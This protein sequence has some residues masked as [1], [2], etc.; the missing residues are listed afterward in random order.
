MEL[1]TTN[2][3]RQ[4]PYRKRLKVGDV[5][6]LAYPGNKFIFG[7]IISLSASVGGFDNCIKIYVYDF[8]TSDAEYLVNLSS[9]KLMCEPLFVNLLGFSRGYMP[10]I[11][12]MHLPDSSCADEWCFH[13][14]PFKKYLDENGIELTKPKQNIG[15][16]GLSNYLVLDDLISKKLD[17][18]LVD[19]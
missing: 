13:D 3:L 15:T 8:I 2:M 14:V 19:D 12:N 6:R 4:V 5:F 17:L 16:W 9:K 1:P 7:Q 18:P 10:I 11:A